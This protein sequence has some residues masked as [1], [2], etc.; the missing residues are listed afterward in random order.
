MKLSLKEFFLHEALGDQFSGPTHGQNS[1][2]EKDRKANEAAD[3]E[4]KAL[5]SYEHPWHHLYSKFKGKKGVKDPAALAAHIKRQELG[6]C[7]L[8]EYEPPET[9]SSKK[10]AKDPPLRQPWEL[11]RTGPEEKNEHNDP[12][13]TPDAGATIWSDPS[14]PADVR[15]FS[16]RG[17]NL[18]VDLKEMFAV[19]EG[20]PGSGRKKG[21]KNKPKEPRVIPG[22]PVD[23]STLPDE[24]DDLD[25]DID[26][27]D[28][29]FSSGATPAAAAP[30]GEDPFAPQ[31]G[32]MG[33]DLSWLD[34][35]ALGA[36]VEMPQREPKAPAAAA[37]PKEHPYT[38]F[39][40]EQ[41][42]PFTP[43]EP[44]D[45]GEFWKQAEAGDWDVM[46]WDELKQAK[47]DVARD[48]EREFPDIADPG[49]FMGDPKLPRRERGSFFAVDAMGDVI[50]RSHGSRFK[51]DAANRDWIP[52]DDGETPSGEF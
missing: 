36:G 43:S 28:D 31:A 46:D 9:R 42:G 10:Y 23:P 37:P 50:M 45:K 2:A 16:S 5:S 22:E 12:T 15:K 3:L 33:D 34:D 32:E 1:S 48:I 35:P 29:G 13:A 38:T 21:S 47:P 49:H 44:V 25:F 51:W 18:C 24:P 27:D 20:G 17:G 30:A 7:E 14:L 41:Y 8:P 39:D 52:M 4:E 26:V 19:S 6:E 40:P 11:G